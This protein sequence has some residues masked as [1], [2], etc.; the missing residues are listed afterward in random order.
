MTSSK[1]TTPL[2]PQFMCGSLAEDVELEAD[3]DEGEEEAHAGEHQAVELE[4]P[5]DTGDPRTPGS[6]TYG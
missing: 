6:R 3:P 2:Q 1:V 4:T 5:L